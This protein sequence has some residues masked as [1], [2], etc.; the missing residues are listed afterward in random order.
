MK[1]SF[2]TTGEVG[3]GEV[4]KLGSEV[5][6]TNDGYTVFEGD[7]CGGAAEDYVVGATYFGT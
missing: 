5:T 7:S 3:T 4:E 1:A 2:V 6:V